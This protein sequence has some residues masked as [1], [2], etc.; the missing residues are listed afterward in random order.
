LPQ[1][2]VSPVSARAVLGAA[3]N[4]VWPGA[5]YLAVGQVYKAVVMI[6]ASYVFLHTVL[7]SLPVLLVA[8]MLLGFGFQPSA[9]VIVYFNV[10]P[11]TLAL[12]YRIGCIADVCM[13]A[14]RVERGD[15]VG[16]WSF[17]NNRAPMEFALRPVLLAVGAIAMVAMVQTLTIVN[18]GERQ[19][20]AQL[21]RECAAIQNAIVGAHPGASGATAGTATPAA[22]SPPISV[23]LDIEGIDAAPGN[24][25]ALVYWHD[26]PEGS[27]EGFNV[28]RVE[29]DG[30]QTMLTHAPEPECYY[31]DTDLTNGATYRYR[32]AAVDSRG[33]QH[34][35]SPVVS[36]TPSASIGDVAWQAPPVYVTGKVELNSVTKS[37][38]GLNDSTVLVD[39]RTAFGDALSGV[40]DFSSQQVEIDTT[41]LSNGRHTVQLIG[42]LDRNSVGVTDPITI[43]VV[44]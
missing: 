23:P 1:H 9:A 22:P 20:D 41:N 14:E 35:L 11:G 39:G 19:A 29:S 33:V 25:C 12:A 42:W 6:F 31:A 16:P 38:F 34:D 44:N 21:A 13:I 18:S 2:A 4:L 5:G 43:D 36:V 37:G 28:F 32:V 24:A 7:G 17:F 26:L 8:R 10:L 40:Y 3:L 27:V 15:D 30:S